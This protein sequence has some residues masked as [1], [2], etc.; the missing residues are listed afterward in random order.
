MELPDYLPLSYLNQLLYCERRFWYMYVQGELAVNAALLE[1]TLRHEHADQPGTERIE[2][3]RVIR[4]LA[5]YSDR[6]RHALLQA[7]RL[8]AELHL[9]VVPAALLASFVLHRPQDAPLLLDKIAEADEPQSVGMD[10][11]PAHHASILDTFRPRL[12][13]VLVAKRAFQQRRIHRQFTVDIHIPE[14]SLAVEQLVQVAEGEV[15]G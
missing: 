3:G 9:I 7:E 11:Q 12:I 14:P 1:G 6:L 10:R 8:C 2:D 15:V 13:G 4:R 5:V